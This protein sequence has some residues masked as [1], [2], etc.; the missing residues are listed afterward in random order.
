MCHE[1]LALT[2]AVDRKAIGGDAGL[3]DADEGAA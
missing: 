1:R 3:F 2:K